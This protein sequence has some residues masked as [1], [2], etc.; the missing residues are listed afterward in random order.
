[1][2]CVKVL[3]ISTVSENGVAVN[4]EWFIWF[5]SAAFCSAFNMTTEAN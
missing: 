3:S 2:N 4:V 5:I 1:V